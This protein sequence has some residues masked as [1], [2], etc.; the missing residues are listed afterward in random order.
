MGGEAAG[1]IS[2]PSRRADGPAESCGQ[3]LDVQDM[4]RGGL[5]AGRCPGL[6]WG[7]W[8]RTRGGLLSHAGC[9]SWHGL[10]LAH[11]LAPK[12]A[13][14]E[15]AGCASS[16]DALPH[17]MARVCFRA[18]SALCSRDGVEPPQGKDAPVPA[19]LRM[20][21]GIMT[22]RGGMAAGGSWWSASPAVPGGQSQG[23]LALGFLCPP[24]S[25]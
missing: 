14:R 7:Q 25:I 16:W 3:H 11:S 21:T 8:G 15:G 19:S 1:D 24:A 23:I 5:R 18:S 4:G 12:Y 6:L 2:A 20:P 10:I 22:R 17:P 13:G 9:A